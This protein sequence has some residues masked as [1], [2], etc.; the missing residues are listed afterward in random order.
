M[1]VRLLA[2]TLIVSACASKPIALQD[3]G[4]LRN[5]SG[6]PAPAK[7]QEA[8]KISVLTFN[9]ENL[10]D[11]QDDPNKNDEAFLPASMK[12]N[13]IFRNKCRAQNMRYKDKANQDE[14]PNDSYQGFRVDECLGK[15]Y[16]ARILARKM[17]RMADVVAQINNGKGPDVLF[18]QEVENEFIVKKW[19]DEYLAKMG[20]QTLFFVEGPDERGI[21]V[22]I[23]SKLPK[24]GEAKYYNIDF[25]KVPEIP[26]DDIRPTRGI[27]EGTVKL[28][29]GENLALFAVHFPSQGA[30]S[31][32]RK[33]AVLTLLEAMDKVPAGTHTIAGGDFNITSIED[34]KY[35]YFTDLISPKYAVSHLI[36]C[37]GC[38]G[39]SYY[40]RDQTWSFFDVLLFSR[41]LLNENSSVK[42]NTQSIRMATDTKWQIDY[43][44]KPAKFRNG[45]GTV[46][47]SDHWPMYAELEMTPAR[48]VGAAK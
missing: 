8:A 11:L 42:L 9:A 43:D 2:L 10:F 1:I 47:V 36:G 48:K 20:Y 38:P 46:G 4:M 25:A 28:P 13:E 45:K 7:N 22:A 35:K 30:S 32:H 26:A 23:L 3:P 18:L 5:P 44:G 21:D 14:R 37:K 16:N 41:S 39:T 6:A 19:R 29:N 31:N 40:N 34:W 15:D 24:A 33:A 17:R 27:L 12:D